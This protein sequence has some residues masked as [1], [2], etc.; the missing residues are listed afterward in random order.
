M[1][2]S[3]YSAGLCGIEGFVVTVECNQRNNLQGFDLVGLPDLAVKEAKE[4]VYTACSNSGYP[5]PYSRI[6][7]NL[8]PADR[9][10]EG[11]AYDVAI[12]LGI[13]KCAGIVKSDL[14]LSKKCFVGELSLSGEVRP[15]PRSEQRISEAEKLGFK[16]I[17]IP[18]HNLQGLDTKKMKIEVIPVRKVEEAFRALFG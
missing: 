17:L 1:L 7:V 11:S 10:K 14:D 15:A 2:S 16:R 8:A 3:T 6:V 9:K 18:K 4:R 13:M 5:F 12:L